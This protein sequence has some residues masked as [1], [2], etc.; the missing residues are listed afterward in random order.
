MKIMSIKEISP[1]D[2]LFGGGCCCFCF[3]LTDNK[4]IR[5]QRV[6]EKFENAVIN[7]LFG[8]FGIG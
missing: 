1:N 8:H 6:R 7:K 2:N 5:Y 3:V 4:N